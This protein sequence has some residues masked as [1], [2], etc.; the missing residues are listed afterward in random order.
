MK[1]VDL[2]A[3]KNA[4]EGVESAP[5][6]YEKGEQIAEFVDQTIDELFRMFYPEDYTRFALMI[7]SRVLDEKYRMIHE[8]EKGIEDHKAKIDEIRHEIETMSS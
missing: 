5:K 4:F 3:F 2:S 7:R 6:I 1:S 8:L